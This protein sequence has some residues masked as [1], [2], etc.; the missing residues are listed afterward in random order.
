[1][2]NEDAIK[3]LQDRLKAK[4][5]QPTMN[6]VIKVIGHGRE[7]Y[8]DGNS[9]PLSDKAQLIARQLY[10]SDKAGETVFA[11]KDIAKTLEMSEKETAGAIKEL[12]AFQLVR[13]VKLPGGPHFRPTKDLLD[14]AANPES[15]G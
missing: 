6:P 12:T 3:N 10:E 1:M 13:E 7:V 11:L 2:T 4:R 9:Y 8:F 14:A 5:D 15:G